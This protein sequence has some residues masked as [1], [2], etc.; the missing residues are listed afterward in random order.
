MGLVANGLLE[1]ML[2]FYLTLRIEINGEFN[3][4]STMV[5]FILYAYV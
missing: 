4:Y 2:Q 5:H 1:H 3:K